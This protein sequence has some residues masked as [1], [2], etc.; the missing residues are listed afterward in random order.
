MQRNAC[1][2][3]L[4]VGVYIIVHP[5]ARTADLTE[6]QLSFQPF[7]NVPL[8]GQARDSPEEK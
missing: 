8:T 3:V 5:N 6:V 1:W 7:L 2:A 4:M